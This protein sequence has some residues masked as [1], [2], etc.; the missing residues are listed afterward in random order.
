MRFFRRLRKKNDH[1][2]PA[3]GNMSAWAGA[4]AHEI[5][6]PLNTMRLNVELLQEDWDQSDESIRAKS[7]KR[8][9]TL[10]KEIS[11]LEEILNDF[12]RFAR[13]PKL[14]LEKSNISLLLNELLDFT[15]PEAQQLNIC[16]IKE[17]SNE[18]PDVY[19]D[20]NQIKQALMNILLNAYQSMSSGG[21]V[22]IK[23]FRVD[24]SV[25]IDITDSGEGIP[26]EK[27]SRIFDLFYS[28]KENGTGLGL[29]IAKRIIEMHNGEIRVNSKKGK[30]TTFSVLMPIHHNT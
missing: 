5:K 9:D 13:L 21:D 19:V 23:V 27:L 3:A 7:E 4:L 17:Y 28:T 18:L 14:N 16:V 29:S 22:V 1:S 30:G 26:Q 11:R 24:S 2:Y 8:L 10:I 15:E 25:C 20:R 6:N 12:L